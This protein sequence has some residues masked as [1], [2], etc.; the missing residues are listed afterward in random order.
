[1]PVGPLV[2]ELIVTVTPAIW[3]VVLSMRPSTIPVTVTGLVGVPNPEKENVKLSAE[4]APAWR[5]ATS[6]EAP[7][8]ARPSNHFGETERARNMEKDWVGNKPEQ[9]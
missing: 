9:P 5:H 3:L 2:A 6:R 7:T 8:T 4:A 1:M